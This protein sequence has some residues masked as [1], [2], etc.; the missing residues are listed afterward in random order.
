MD[1]DINIAIVELNAASKSNGRN[2]SK[3]SG[4]YRICHLTEGKLTQ[5]SVLKEVSKN[6]NNLLC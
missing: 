2:V 6:S 4:K 5:Q 1:V 3:A